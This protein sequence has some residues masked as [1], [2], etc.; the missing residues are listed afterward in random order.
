VSELA[1]PVTFFPGLASVRSPALRR[2][3]TDTWEAAWELSDLGVQIHDLPFTISAPDESL[4]VHVNR[5]VE[6]ALVLET[7]A[8]AAG[9]PSVDHDTLVGA[10]LLHDVDKVCLLQPSKNGDWEPTRWSRRYQHGYLGAML[11]RDHGV[12]E[13]IVHLVATHTTQSQL[14]PEPFEGVI[15]HYADLFAA[16]AAL[17]AAGATL[18]MAPHTP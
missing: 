9:F 13:E 17:Y 11:C 12:P 10:C 1:S 7:Y 3:V 8:S 18:L 5:V 6:V 2:Q 15:L 4:I 16:D 14:V